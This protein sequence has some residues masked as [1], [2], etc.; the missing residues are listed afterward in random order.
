[1]VSALDSRSNSPGSSLG[2]DTA[3]CSWARHFTL[4]VPL[5]TQVSK[6]IPANLRLGVTLRWTSIPSRGGGGGGV[7]ILL[8]TSC[9]GNWDNFRLINH[10]TRMQTLPTPSREKWR[11]HGNS[12]EL[13]G[14]S[15]E[16]P[17]NLHGTPWS[18]NRTS[19]DLHGVSMEPPWNSLE[20]LYGHPMDTQ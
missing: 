4:K 19:M 17:W 1:M 18:F 10:L 2:R 16:F 6:W 8:V 3:L 9:Y 7:E 20:I 15:M 5:S 13:R 11:F 12:M 14:D